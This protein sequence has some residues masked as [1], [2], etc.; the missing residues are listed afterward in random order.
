MSNRTCALIGLFLVALLALGACGQLT[1]EMPMLE[2]NAHV[3]IHG[4]V[5]YNLW[6][7]VTNEPTISANGHDW[8][9]IPLVRQRTTVRLDPYPVYAYANEAG[10]VF[11][12][13]AN[14]AW[15]TPKPAQ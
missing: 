3:E 4:V 11:L 5:F 6:N 12:T 8:H 14:Q 9:G 7:P 2:P 10:V 15:P 13:V 1:G